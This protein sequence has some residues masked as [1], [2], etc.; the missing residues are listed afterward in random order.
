MQPTLRQ[1]PYGW[2]ALPGIGAPIPV[3]TIGTTEDEA[4]R[5]FRESVNGWARLRALPDPE[6]AAPDA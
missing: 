3:C 4:L 2:I 5:R 1:T 6:W